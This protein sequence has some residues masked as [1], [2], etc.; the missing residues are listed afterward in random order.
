MDTN[1]T[2]IMSLVKESLGIIATATVKD[3]EIELLIRTA[4]A[5]MTRLGIDVDLTKPMHKNAIRNYCKAEFGMTDPATKE[6]CKNHIIFSF[7]LS[8]QIQMKRRI[9]ND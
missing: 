8:K 3:N 5:D 7:P 9:K 1:L 4:M 6:Q 2:D